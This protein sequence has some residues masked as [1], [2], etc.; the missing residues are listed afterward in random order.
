MINKT[1]QFAKNLLPYVI[2]FFVISILLL[3]V[4][5]NI[6]EG[7]PPG[8]DA[9]IYIMDAYSRLETHKYFERYYSDYLGRST[10]ES[11]I[12]SVVLVGLHKITGL[13]IEYPLFMIYQSFLLVL[14]FIL[15][16]F[17]AKKL[18]NSYVAAVLS[19]LLLAFNGLYFL[20]YSSTVANF[21][22]INLV[23]LL[24]LMILSLK[25]KSLIFLVPLVLILLYFSHKSLTFIL[26]LATLI[27]MFGVYAKRIIKSFLQF[28]IVLKV[29]LGILFCVALFL[30]I[31]YFYQPFSQIL[32]SESFGDPSRFREKISFENYLAIIGEIL[33]VFFIISFFLI[34]KEITDYR[35]KIV[36]TSIF[37]FVLLAISFSLLPYFGVYLFSY[38]MLYMVWPLIY[39]PIAF[40]LYILIQRAGKRYSLVF[41]VLLFVFFLQEA[42]VTNDS[43]AERT[44]FISDQQV[45]ALRFLKA[46]SSFG[47]KVLINSTKIHPFNISVA[48]RVFINSTY[49]TFES[50]LNKINLQDKG[51]SHIVITEGD[52]SGKSVVEYLALA[53]ERDYLAEIYRDDQTIIFSV[54]K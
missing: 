52:K 24:M 51:I 39:I 54:S 27:L 19:L 8:S 42:K 38:R 31:K 21:L 10:Y 28:H 45:V 26:T 32:M 16:F 41:F 36:L 43:T 12:H 40:A 14:I 17:L 4:C 3:L 20:I 2:L 48:T 44:I 37:I 50:D 33:S 11:P 29:T 46:N 25:T 1:L 5:P 35:K 6:K 18:F 30:L 47:D 15:S 23:L 34:R 7:V 49:D 13:N 9:N 53:Q 22:G